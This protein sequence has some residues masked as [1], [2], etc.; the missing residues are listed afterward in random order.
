[1]KNK[2][3]DA[4]LLERKLL[5]VVIDMEMSGVPLSSDIVHEQKYWQSEFNAGEE[6]LKHLTNGVKPGTKA[7]FNK[8]RE[9]KLIDESKIQYTPKGNPRYG[10]EFLADL[11]TDENLS[12]ILQRRSKLQ[13]VL[14]T[15]INPW[16]ES[17]A[18]YGRF[19]PYFQQTR[20]DN[21]YGTR[22]GRFSSNLQQIP[23]VS[24]DS[25]IPNLRKY[26]VPE[27]GHVILKRDYSSQEIRVSAHYAEGSIM[28]AFQ[29][30]PEMDVH[31]FV[32]KLIKT[33]TKRQLERRIVKTISFLKLY[34]GGPQKLA[35]NLGV[36]ISDAQ[37][38]FEAYDNALPEF[39]QLAVDV[40][41]QVRGGTLL[42]TWGGRLYD[43][44]PPKIVNGKRREFYYKLL[45]ILIQGSSADMSKH[46]MVRYWHHP[47]R[48]GRILLVVHDELVLTVP[49][50]HAKS[51]MKLLKWAMEDQEG[52]DVKMLTDGKI[53]PSFGELEDF[54]V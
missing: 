42:R 21:D 14:G 18:Q 29:K 11:I 49:E 10:R 45:N 17:F 27:P 50:E 4:Y 15:Y 9:L 51:E 52:W 53:G 12:Q 40:E 47:D 6:Y 5:P 54:Y 39:K 31:N 48:K 36:L 33:K 26:I 20:G 3:H 28:K 43:V 32:Q 35:D 2:M 38:F 46:A 34:G 16:A 19:F 44:E 8:L 13:K 30:D 25:S 1:M 7:M 23:H 37:S 22:T 24:H 41:R